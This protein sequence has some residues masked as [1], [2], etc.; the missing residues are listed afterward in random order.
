[1]R[2]CSAMEITLSADASELSCGE[3]NL[4]V[5]AVRS[6]EKEFGIRKDLKITLKK[7]IPVAAGMA[8]GST[9]AAAAL[10]AAVEALS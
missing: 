7:R 10:R 2:D 3:D 6:M 5:R 8:G 9:D 1:M 4:I